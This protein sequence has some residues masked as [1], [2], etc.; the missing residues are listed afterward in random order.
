M[1][2]LR[3]SALGDSVYFFDCALTRVRGITAQIDVTKCII[4]LGKLM[5]HSVIFANVQPPTRT[6][7]LAHT[8]AHTPTLTLTHH[9]G[10]QTL[11]LTPP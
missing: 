7:A 9:P 6:L 11:T 2:P 4:R 10:L 8:L 1:W 5:S 3:K